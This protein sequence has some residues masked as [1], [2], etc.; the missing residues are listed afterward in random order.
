MLA[1]QNIFNLRTESDIMFS[2]KEFGKITIL[3]VF[4][5]NAV[6]SLLVFMVQGS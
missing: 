5:N 4:V 3:F 2:A 1:F 6:V